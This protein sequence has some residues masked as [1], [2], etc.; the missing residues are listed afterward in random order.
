M[1]EPHRLSPKGQ[2]MPKTHPPYTPEFR[3]QMV[4]LVRAVRDP[5]DLAKEFEPT[6]QSIR[7][8]FAVADKREGRRPEAD[9]ALTLAEREELARLRRENKYLRLEH[10][11]LSRATAW[12]ARET[13]IGLPPEGWRGEIRALRCR[14]YAGLGS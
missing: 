2:F 6:A 4:A 14:R 10:D 12:F 8:W 5:D 9:G 7:N 13:N 11:I 1:V 3:R